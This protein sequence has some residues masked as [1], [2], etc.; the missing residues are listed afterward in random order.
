MSDERGKLPTDIEGDPVHQAA[1]EW[2][3]RLQNTEVS[4]EDAL[5]W[6]AWIN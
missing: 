6:Q 3:V 1:A 5:A 4:I 2:F